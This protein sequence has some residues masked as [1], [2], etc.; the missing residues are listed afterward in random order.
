[1]NETIASLLIWASQL[2]GYGIPDQ[3]VTV[4]IVSKE[5]MG[6]RACPS[7]PS[8]CRVM[9]LYD[10]NNIVY[11]IEGLTWQAQDHILLH[12]L[13]HYLQHHSGKYSL[14]RCIDTVLREREAYHVQ[15]LYIW[16]V[17][18]GIAG[19]LPPNATCTE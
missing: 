10:D 18:G 15:N 13:V 17:Q 11:V 12:E 3:P 9:G 6:Q 1:M 4:Q 8:R 5:W 7:N 14:E 16:H 2:T 19:M